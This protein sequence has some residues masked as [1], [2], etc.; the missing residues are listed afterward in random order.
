[1]VI[2]GYDPYPTR[3]IATGWAFDVPKSFMRK[4]LSE[5]IDAAK[6]ANIE[7][8]GF[9]PI[10]KNVLLLN[11]NLSTIQGITGAHDWRWFTH[12]IIEHIHS[13]KPDVEFVFLGKY[14]QT[15][16]TVGG[17]EFA[18]PAANRVGKKLFDSKFFTQTKFPWN[19]FYQTTS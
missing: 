13:Y 5:F 2:V 14:A 11:A 12:Q 3:L 17:A 4:S 7:F 16:N 19:D 10:K 6:D 9:E 8:T 18:H 1:M 15:L